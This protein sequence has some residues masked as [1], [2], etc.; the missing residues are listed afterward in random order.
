MVI[1]GIDALQKGAWASILKQNVNIFQITLRTS[2]T[3]CIAR[4][5][6]TV[7]EGVEGAASK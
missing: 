2:S 1:V 6:A 4:K 5:M 7:G 3:N